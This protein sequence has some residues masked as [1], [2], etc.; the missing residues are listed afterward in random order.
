MGQNE[1]I[2]IPG[3]KFDDLLSQEFVIKGS[4]SN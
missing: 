1:Q 2:S 3:E 4:A